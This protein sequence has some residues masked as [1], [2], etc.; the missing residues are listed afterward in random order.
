MVLLSFGLCLVL[1]V[2]TPY[3]EI[4]AWHV[5]A[6]YLSGLSYCDLETTKSMIH[7]KK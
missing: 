4:A 5:L 1:N 2:V 3:R 6:N 7:G